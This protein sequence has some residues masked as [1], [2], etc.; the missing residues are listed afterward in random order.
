MKDGF[1]IENLHQRIKTIKYGSIRKYREEGE[2][3]KS[4]KRWPLCHSER[5]EE[6]M[7]FAFIRRMQRSFA[8]P[9]GCA[10]EDDC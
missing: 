1:F 9:H 2:C 4:G 7:H 5:S 8:A 10:Q 3:F 6:S